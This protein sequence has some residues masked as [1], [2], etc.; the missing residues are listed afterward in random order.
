MTKREALEIML[1]QWDY[2]SCN[3]GNKEN[4]AKVLKL[5]Q[6]EDYHNCSCCEY[7]GYSF[8]HEESGCKKCPIVWPK[9]YRYADKNDP[10]CCKSYFIQW[11]TKSS[12]G[13]TLAGQK[14]ALK[15]A[16]LALDTLNKEWPE[17]EAK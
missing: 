14:Y 10:P 4:A 13:Y 16:S 7:S 2:I 11:F 8:E 17:K 1:M 9:T 12:N 15:I 5:K 3:G 6:S